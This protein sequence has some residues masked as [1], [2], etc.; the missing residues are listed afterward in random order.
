[1]I[2]ALALLLLLFFR[3]SYNTEKKSYWST[4]YI[5]AVYH[6]TGTELIELPDFHIWLAILPFDVCTSMAH[7][8]ILRLAR[9]PNI[10]RSKKKWQD[11]LFFFF[12]KNKKK[13][14][15]IDEIRK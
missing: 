4:D 14:P 15:G 10:I 13:K 12:T 11:F 3:A 9:V 8:K 7:I 1:M 5:I 2:L 6:I